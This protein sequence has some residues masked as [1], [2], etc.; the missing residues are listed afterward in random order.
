[1]RL[2]YLYNFFFIYF[3]IYVS[4]TQ[5][6]FTKKFICLLA[7]KSSSLTFKDLLVAK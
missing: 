6:T 1:M 5:I 2:I 7:V 3:D 4:A